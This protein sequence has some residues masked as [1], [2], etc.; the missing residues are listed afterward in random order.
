MEMQDQAAAI[1]RDKQ[2]SCHSAYSRLF[3][4]GRLT[5]G[6]IAPLET[7]PGRTTPTMKDHAAMASKADEQGFG[8]L[9]LRDIPF[10][11]PEYGDVGQ[12]FD[13]IAYL[14]FLIAHTKNIALGTAGL[15]LPFREPL[16][17]GKQI[18]SLDN[19]SESRLLFGISSGD[20]P[21]EYPMFG[22]DF[23]TRGERFRETYDLFKKVT[24]QSYPEF[25][26]AR[27]GR[28][29]GALDLLPK[30]MKGI[31]P[32]IAIGH[33]QQDEDWIAANLDG[34]IRAAPAPAHFHAITR[35]WKSA[36][37]STGNP[38]M[39]KPLGVGC[40]L[41]L[42]DDPSAPLF[43]IPGGFRVGRYALKDFLELAQDAGINHVALNPKASTR[44]FR[45]I[46]D[47]IALD[48]LPLFSSN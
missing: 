10:F 32:A 28:G 14:G 27:F 7:H 36:L 4:K 20:R 31:I 13:P 39:F 29:T 3:A 9:W 15:V 19:L 17:L 18:A 25:S 40:Y 48:I 45:E 1:N 26:S 23:D 38:D 46:M 21:A 24:E 30:P 35:R 2:L 37:Q 33:A 22:V 16:I 44:P 42:V 41:D 11:D 34:L 8:A 5:I 6:L 47:E 12:V 43:R